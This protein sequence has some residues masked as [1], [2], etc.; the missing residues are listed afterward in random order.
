MQLWDIGKLNERSQNPEAP[1]SKYDQS[2]LPA[3]LSVFAQ[4]NCSVVIET[5]MAVYQQ[6][7][8]QTLL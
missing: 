6:E 8:K 5:I 4:D 2:E 3:T 1:R 7:R